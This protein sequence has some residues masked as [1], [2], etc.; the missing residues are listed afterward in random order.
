MIWLC[1][2]AA[3]L[4]DM[5]KARRLQSSRFQAT[6]SPRSTCRGASSAAAPPK[7]HRPEPAPCRLTASP[8]RPI[9]QVI[10]SIA[11]IP[12]SKAHSWDPGLLG[13]LQGLFFAGFAVTQARAVCSRKG[14][15]NSACTVLPSDLG[16]SASSDKAACDLAVLTFI[17]C[18]SGADSQRDVGRPPP[19]GAAASPRGAHMVAGAP[20]HGAHIPRSQSPQPGSRRPAH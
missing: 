15:P 5:D 12:L 2:V 10:M 11:G 1:A 13:V 18:S 3:A 19:R 7:Q 20:L 9:R 16:G 6:A 17:A 14:R 4:S 8:L